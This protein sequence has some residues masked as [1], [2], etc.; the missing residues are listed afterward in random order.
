MKKVIM[1][2]LC[3]LLLGC[4]NSLKNDCEDLMDENNQLKVQI[5]ELTDELNDCKE[6]LDQYD[7]YE[8]GK[9]KISGGL[10]LSVDAKLDDPH[11]E[12]TVENVLVVRLFQ[13]NHDIIRVSDEI[14]KEVEIGETYFFEIKPKVIEDVSVN[15]VQEV[16]SLDIGAM[17]WLEVDRVREPKEDEYGLAENLHI[18]QVDK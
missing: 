10:V 1:S 3:F 6:E 15:E 12:S 9:V 2:L 13:S 4:S 17:Q 11:T 16:L 7:E 8:K 14:A 18:E 5:Q